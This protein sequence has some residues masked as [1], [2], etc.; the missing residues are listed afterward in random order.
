MENLLEINLTKSEK[1]KV[2][3]AIRETI[4]SVFYRMDDS[5]L[6]EFVDLSLT[7]IQVPKGL[8]INVMSKANSV[9]LLGE[10]F[11][12]AKPDSFEQKKAAFKLVNCIKDKSDW[13]YVLQFFWGKY[14]PT[15]NDFERMLCKL[16]VRKI[17]QIIPTMTL[18]DFI[19]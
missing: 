6:E 2:I 11:L 17:A 15:G 12:K 10:K 19:P 14:S 3:K 18:L 16:I 7:Y 13:G 4:F 1:G 5:E 8:L 9:L